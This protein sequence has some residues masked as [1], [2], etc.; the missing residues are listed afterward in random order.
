MSFLNNLSNSLSSAAWGSGVGMIQGMQMGAGYTYGGDI[1]RTINGGGTT[2]IRTAVG[3][4]V[5]YFHTPGVQSV[6]TPPAAASRITPWGGFGIANS[7]IMTGAAFY[8]GGVQAGAHSIVQDLS[9]GAGL[10]RWGHQMRSYNGGTA[11]ITAGNLGR[12]TPV[13]EALSKS[14]KLG[15]GLAQGLGGASYVS[16]LA[17]G[18][19]AQGAID[20][21]LGTGILSNALTPVATGMGARYSPYLL[22]G[23]IMAGGAY[24]AGRTA[25]SVVRAGYDYRQ[26]QK[27]IQTSGDLMAFNTGAALTM[28]ARAVQAIQNSHQNSR[29]ALGQEAQFIHAPQRNYHSPYRSGY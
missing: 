4:H 16:R 6:Y 14:G 28:R 22:G 7:L 29:T 9:L 12:F 17:G 5:D 24:L 20:A 10:A 21:M 8:T 11:G 26:H 15:R 13:Y 1:E 27:S 18:L 3:S 19:V 23:S 25:Y 2:R